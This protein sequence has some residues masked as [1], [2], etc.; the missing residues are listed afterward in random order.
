LS[1]ALF[2]PGTRDKLSLV[3]STAE[4]CSPPLCY[5]FKI[6][7]L[8]FFTPLTSHAANDHYVYSCRNEIGQTIYILC[9]PWPCLFRYDEVFFGIHEF[10][11][12][13]G[14]F[15]ISALSYHWNNGESASKALK[16]DKRVIFRGSSAHHKN[17][18]AER[19]TET[20]DHW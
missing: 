5:L 13:L 7:N 3:L 20:A 4:S 17:G 11:S 18:D 6:D 12:I 16:M 1:Q 15:G 10:D 19:S 9:Y 8:S 14:A 2:W